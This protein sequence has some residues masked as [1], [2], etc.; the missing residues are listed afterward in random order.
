MSGFTDV[1]VPDQSGKCFI[2]T[3]ANSGLGY[4]T[5]K[6]LA[7]KGARILMACRNAAKADK[8]IGSIRAE[9][10]LADLVHLQLPPGWSERVHVRVMDATGHLVTAFDAQRHGPIDVSCLARGAYFLSVN[11]GA[12]RAVARFIAH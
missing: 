3:G 5:S 7:R 4:E 2:V 1:D 6:V 12:H 11:D 8:A 10:P 9:V